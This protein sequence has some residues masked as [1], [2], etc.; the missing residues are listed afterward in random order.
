[1]LSQPSQPKKPK[2][3]PNQPK[4]QSK[5][6]LALVACKKYG[7]VVFGQKHKFE[8]RPEI[9][10]IG[11]FGVVM[12][13]RYLHNRVECVAKIVDLEENERKN[14]IKILNREVRIFQEMNQHPRL[15]PF[16]VQVY[17]SNHFL[18]NYQKNCHVMVMAYAGKDLSE[19]L[20]MKGDY[21]F[22]KY[23]LCRIG[24]E[25]V[26]GLQA[27]HACG[28][29][30]RDIKPQNITMIVS[31]SQ[32]FMSVKLV[33][34]GLA[35]KYD[36]LHPPTQKN[37][38]LGT[39][40]YCAWKQQTGFP[41]SPARD[42]ES[43]LY[44]LI[45]LSGKTLPWKGLNISDTAAHMRLIGETKRDADAKLLCCYL[46]DD[47][48]PVQLSDILDETRVLKFQEFPDYKKLVKYLKQGLTCPALKKQKKQKKRKS[49]LHPLHKSSRPRLSKPMNGKTRIS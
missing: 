3:P 31:K 46:D 4:K 15:A 33:D 30:H 27:L 26:P 40:R 38:C 49:M 14:P 34:Y 12:K 32:N 35:M 24:M 25:L 48:D 44:T 39:P 36:P 2:K 8:I 37:K 43:L 20:A 5:K 1:M 47:D 45:Y 22:S 21:A 10:G 6:Q 23:Q 16:L 28:F 17:Y 42:I 11:S 9:L 29:V 41:G 19:I 18:D 13:C 7:H